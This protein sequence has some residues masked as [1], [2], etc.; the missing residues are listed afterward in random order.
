MFLSLCS[1]LFLM[2]L[3]VY[4]I[5][6]FNTT[7]LLICHAFVPEI[8]VDVTEFYNLLPSMMNPAIVASS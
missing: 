7:L 3:Y 4:N 1:W 5:C 6:H 2:V 8:A